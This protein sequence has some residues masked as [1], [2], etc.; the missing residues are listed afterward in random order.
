MFS[1]DDQ[2]GLKQVRCSFK[3][4]CNQLT[5]AQWVV[6]APLIEAVRP[7]A[8]V[9]PRYLR[10]TINVIAWRH[11][12]GAKWR[13]VS[14]ELGPWRMAAQ[15]FIRWSRCYVWERLLTL[16]QEQGV[17]LGMIFLDGTSIPAANASRFGERT[18]K[19]SGRGL[20]PG[21]G[22]GARVAAHCGVA[23]ATAGR[24][25]LGGRRSRLQQPRLLRA[26][27]G[28]GRAACDPA[29]AERGTR[30][31]PGLDL[32]APQPSRAALG[33]AQGMARRRHAPREDGQLLHGRPLRGR[34]HRLDQ[35]LTSHRSAGCRAAPTFRGCC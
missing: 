10:R 16:V 29:Q 27:L 13:A 7:A 11:D 33:Q 23:R 14:N 2:T 15:T 21:A 4:R 17:Q 24:T 5:D 9:P 6:L 28:L 3:I 22:A 34:S 31:L 35:R 25:R 12:N 1:A 8:K 26:H 20:C 19:R 18:R 32:H 30:G